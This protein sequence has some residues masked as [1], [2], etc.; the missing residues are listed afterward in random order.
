MRLLYVVDRFQAAWPLH[1]RLRGGEMRGLVDRRALIGTV[2]VIAL[3]AAWG[4]DAVRG[5]VERRA[6]GAASVR[7]PTGASAEAQRGERALG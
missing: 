6:R 5:L 7:V 1:F 3:Q 2:V 4:G